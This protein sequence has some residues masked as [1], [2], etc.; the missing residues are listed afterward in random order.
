MYLF[1]QA[2]PTCLLTI[3]EL[4]L[5][6]HPEYCYSGVVES[7][8]KNVV[9]DGQPCMLEILDNALWSEWIDD[10]EAFVLAYS[11][12]SRQSFSEIPEIYRHVQR[13]KQAP[14]K[15]NKGFSSPST[16]VPT[17]PVPIIILGNMSDR[18]AD[19]EVSTQ[20]AQA[21]ATKLGCRFMECSARNSSNIEKGFFD[22]VRMMRE[23]RLG[24]QRSTHSIPA[25]KESRLWSLIKRYLWRKKRYMPTNEK[26]S[27]AGRKTLP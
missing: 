7:Y 10:G 27:K 4:V 15:S 18:D 17:D 1:G 2:R 14:A 24:A 12:N 9:I 13:L 19:R 25:A 20:E 26:E 23:Q 6:C 8:R 16:S 3:I 21:L 11:V 22:L 5:N